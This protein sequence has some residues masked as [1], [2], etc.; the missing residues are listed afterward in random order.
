MSLSAKFGIELQTKLKYYIT[1][2]KATL[3]HDER[4]KDRARR[5]GKEREGKKHFTRVVIFT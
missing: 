1:K 4:W 2:Q 5:P 3:C